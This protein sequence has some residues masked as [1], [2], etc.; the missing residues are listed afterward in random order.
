MRRK[1]KNRKLSLIKKPETKRSLRL[2]KKLK[3][4]RMRK[5]RKSKDLES[6]KR[7]PLIDRLR[8]MLL[9]PKEPSKK[10]R[11]RLEK[12]RDSSS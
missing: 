1:N 11:D 4:S 12:E 9:E 8:S 7:R 10:E 5:K 2:P 3:E 6:S